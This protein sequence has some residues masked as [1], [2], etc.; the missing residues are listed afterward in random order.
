MVTVKKLLGRAPTSDGHFGFSSY[1]NYK[2]SYV[3]GMCATCQCPEINGLQN[4][5]NLSILKC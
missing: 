2:T 4:C 1:Y 5:C 3:L